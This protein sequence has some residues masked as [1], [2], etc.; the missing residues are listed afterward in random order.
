M[1]SDKYWLLCM[2]CGEGVVVWR[3]GEG[4]YWILKLIRMR[5]W[6]RMERNGVV[7]MRIEEEWRSGRIPS[8]ICGWR[9][10]EEMVLWLELN[11]GV[12]GVLQNAFLPSINMNR[13][14]AEDFI[15]HVRGMN[16]RVKWDGLV[17]VKEEC[18]FSSLEREMKSRGWRD[19]ESAW[20]EFESRD[21]FPLLH[22]FPLPFF[23]I[24]GTNN[25]YLLLWQKPSCFALNAEFKRQ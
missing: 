9:E 5:W 6:M 17:V 3:R 16:G 7:W 22:A 13:R 24:R 12:V 25:A 20:V 21:P 18:G 1:R 14:R 10:D 2:E 8:R 23:M 19:A 15:L 11:D 4:C